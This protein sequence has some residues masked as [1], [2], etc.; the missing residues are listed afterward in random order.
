[1]PAPVMV[2]ENRSF[3]LQRT[4]RTALAPGAPPA[5]TERAEPSHASR[6]AVDMGTVAPWTTW[7]TPVTLG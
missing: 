1:M 6:T 2:A 5:R 7:C 4:A 3:V